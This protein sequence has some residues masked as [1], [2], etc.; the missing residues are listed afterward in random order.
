MIKKKQFIS[1]IVAAFLASGYALAQ[2]PFDGTYTFGTNGN[3]SSFP[4]NGTPVTGLDVSDL[5]KNGVTSTS[6][7]GNFRASGWSTGSTIDTGDYFEFTLTADSGFQLDLTSI[8]FGIGRSATG[9]VNWEWRSSADGFA[10]TISTYTSLN[11]DLL[12]NGGV[13]TAPDLNSSWTGNVLDLSGSPYQDLTTITFRFY[14]YTTEG[15]AGTGGF[16]GPLSFSGV[17]ETSGG[18]GANVSIGAGNTF[19][20]ASFGGAAFTAADTAVFDGTPG[21]VNL[22]GNVVAAKLDFLGNGYELSGGVADSISTPTVSVDAGMTATISGK[23]TGE[24]SLSK[25]GSG[26]LVLSG[27]NDFVGNVILAAGGVSIANDFNLGD[28]TNGI[29]LGSSGTLIANGDVALNSSRSI[30]GAGSLASSS[31]QTLTVNGVV[32]AG[33]NIAGSGT[34]ALAG[35]SNTLTSLTFSEA[36]V[37]AVTG[38]TASMAGNLGST[39]TD[40]TAR[41]IGALDFGAAPVTRTIT[42]ADGAADVDFELAANL[43]SGTSTV[44]L[45]KLGDGT[46]RLSGDNSAL[47]GGFRLGNANGAYGG[48]LVVTGS[49]SLGGAQFQFNNGI[50]EVENE[51]T[52]GIG[53]SFGGVST[54]P[55]VIQGANVTFSGSS[56]FFTTSGMSNLVQVN[57]TTTLAGTLVHSGSGGSSLWIGGSGTLKVTGDASGVVAPTSVLNTATLV[58]D[59][60]WGSS[61][62]VDVNATLKGNGVIAGLMEIYGKHAVGNSAGIQTAAGG[63]SYM[64]GSAFEWELVGNSNATAGVDFDQL[65]VSG[66]NISIDGGV[67]MQLVFN[68]VGSTVDWTDSFWDT[69][70]SWT[71]VDN[72]GGGSLAGQFV[73]NSASE[74]FDANGFLLSSID[75]DAQFV[76]STVDGDIVLTYYAVPIPEPS[77]LAFLG[78]AGVGLLWSRRR[79][80]V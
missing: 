60:N 79:R 49:N 28:S 33:L 15:A 48:R 58:V 24:N 61:I 51:T 36:G 46:L 8:S 35:A 69:D 25:V 29:V 38:G 57:N 32:N 43:I 14:G 19:T 75:P 16:Q 70:H 68:S 54:A 11:A 74:W 31:G 44:R 39:H 77:T 78:F 71:L 17:L 65:V 7:S 55:S 6:S 42:V 12:S 52:F 30:S 4:Y 80:T 64:S 72:T 20:P 76:L 34:V 59:S 27:S 67:T 45:H 13:L 73:L 21:N 47:Q 5:T 40:G 23:I 10:S 1:P 56:S 53:V 9:P 63:V 18:G 50:L 62:L 66:G 22:S 3:V 26:L 2:V 37:L 41:V